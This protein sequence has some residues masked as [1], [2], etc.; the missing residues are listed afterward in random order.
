VVWPTAPIP[1]VEPISAPTAFDQSMRS[2]ELCPAVR[3]AHAPENAELYATILNHI[4]ARIRQLAPQGI[5]QVEFALANCEGM[6][7]RLA[8]ELRGGGF[9]AIPSLNYTGQ[10][11]LSIGWHDAPRKLM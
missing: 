9:V 10:T 4:Y 8:E 6:I 1:W 7:V 11:Y 5:Q 2:A 3:A